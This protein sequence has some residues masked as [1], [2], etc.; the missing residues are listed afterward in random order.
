MA[1]ELYWEIV[2][3]DP[4]GGRLEATDTSFWFG[5]KDDVVMRVTATDDG[6]SR[7][8]VRSVSR[9]GQGDLGANAGRIREFLNRLQA[10]RVLP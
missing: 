6:R 4:E 1:E 3:A 2:A 8:D 10:P 5:F 7:V 9:V